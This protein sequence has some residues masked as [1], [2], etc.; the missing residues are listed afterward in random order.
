MRKLPR[1]SDIAELEQLRVRL[2]ASEEEK[3]KRKVLTVKEAA[4]QLGF[5]PPTIYRAVR[6]GYIPFIRIGGRIL[7]PVAA[8][9]KML[10]NDGT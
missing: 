7:I 5:S 6:N 1:F 9:E 10:G 2:I 3:H 4:E 8:F